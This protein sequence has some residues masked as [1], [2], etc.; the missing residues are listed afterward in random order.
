[1]TVACAVNQ[2]WTYQTVRIV[3]LGKSVGGTVSNAASHSSARTLLVCACVSTPLAVVATRARCKGSCW[4][5]EFAR[6]HY[7]LPRR[8][9]GNRP[10]LID[11]S[12]QRGGPPPFDAVCAPCRKVRGVAIGQSKYTSSGE[13][14]DARVFASEG[15]LLSIAFQTAA[16]KRPS[17]RA[18]S[19]AK[20]S[21]MRFALY[22]PKRSSSL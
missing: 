20:I 22:P 15:A 3:W 14:V 6:G 16:L 9:Q 13:N 5:N 8:G 10:S 2:F 7:H 17:I 4:T 19:S 11:R 12:Q 18:Y 1:M 21:S